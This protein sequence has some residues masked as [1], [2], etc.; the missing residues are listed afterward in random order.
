MMQDTADLPARKEDRIKGM[1]PAPASP[2]STISPPPALIDTSFLSLI[3]GK[4]AGI[5]PKDHPID[6]AFLKL[7]LN[8]SFSCF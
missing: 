5:I 7:S 4:R 2:H 6:K 3:A 1:L 8:S